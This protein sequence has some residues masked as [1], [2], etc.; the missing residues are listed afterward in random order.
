VTASNYK[1]H[2]FD[3]LPQLYHTYDEGYGSLGAFLH[4]LGATL[5]D[6]EKN[7][8]ELYGDSFI[9][10]C[11]AWVIPYI[12]QMIGARILESEG[13]RSRQEVM[14]TIDWR[15]RKGTLAAL[16]DLA[17]E[18]TG[19]G[20]E[21]AEFFEQM[22]W[23]QNLNHIKLDH[24]QSPDLAD[25]SALF[26][27]DG[28]ENKLLHTVDIRTP[29]NQ[30]GWFQIK[31]LGFFTAT[32][33]LNHYRQIPLQRVFGHPYQFRVEPMRYPINLFNGQSCFPLAQTLE[34]EE[35]IDGFGTGLAVDVH[36]QGILT[37]APA[38]PR[39]IGAPA[40][41]P[42]DPVILD[43]K[44]GDGLWP[45]D[46][47]VSG[48][49]PLK[50]TLT[51]MVL[52][53]K[54]GKAKLEALGHLDLNALPLE[55][56][57]TADGGSKPKPRLVMAVKPQSGYDRAFP[58]MVLRVTSTHALYE[59]FPGVEDRQS[60]I[61]KDR[62]Y[63][64]LPAV[65]NG[66]ESY[67]ALDRYGSAYSYQHDPGHA[68][69][70]DEELFDFT[71]LARVS[72]GVVCPSRELTAANTPNPPI[73]SLAKTRTLQVVDRGQFLSTLIPAQGFIIKAW[74]R[75]NQPGGGVLRLLAAVAITSPADKPVVTDLVNQ[76]C[77]GP[78]H[79]IISLHRGATDRIPE[80]E[81]IVM[82]ERG[83]ALLAYLPQVD[84]MEPEGAFFYVAEDGAT[85]RVNAGAI[86]GGLL[87]PR[88]PDA[89]LE[90]GFNPV[91]LARLSAGQCLPIQNKTPIQQRIA[92]RCDLSQNAIPCPGILAIDPVIG[93]IAFAKNERPSLPLAAGYHHGLQARV[94]AGA[95]F[96]AQTDADDETRILHVSKRSAPDDHWHLR[97]PADG[98]MS[99]V[100][101]HAC[102]QDA[103]QDIINQN[104]SSTGQAEPWIIQIEDSE[105]Y[106]ENLNI[107]A[108]IPCGLIMR[109]AQFQYPV[110]NGPIIWNGPADQ[111]TPLA[112][113]QGL[114]LGDTVR[115]RTG[116]FQ[117]IRFEDCTLLNRILILKAVR[118][119]EDR[120]PRV[121]VS[122]SIMRSRIS[123][124]GD[125][126]VRIEDSALDPEIGSA[127]VARHGEIEMECC[128]VLG[129][130]KA[131]E[132]SASESIFM[133]PVTVYDPQKGCMRYCR[134]TATG[135]TLPRTYRCTTAEV[136]FVHDQPWHSGYLKIRRSCN[137]A[138][139]RWAENG[140]EIGVYHQ[141]GYTLKEKNLN[142]KFEEYLPVGLTPVLIDKGDEVYG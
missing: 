110:I 125:C 18:I 98:I 10:S 68:Q 113:F 103:L 141:A 57:H 108:A 48:G 130:V 38:L 75:D 129:R 90:G 22:G 85:Y 11:H 126:L 61:Y 47:R 86:S 127:L 31:N 132:L 14:K 25:H 99:R 51:P 121:S 17:R 116:R 87:V 80:M 77:E 40:V 45:M 69:P 50:Y 128:T 27:Q 29:G 26:H 112:A 93:Q 102:I 33:A 138:V 37:A 16:E 24:L 134:I 58:A 135:N 84:D 111:I 63:V 83:K 7:I 97:P 41:A 115:F 114:V 62:L 136:T 21:A 104:A 19:W 2:L 66:A 79:L 9:E 15:K 96:H 117:K 71:R 5:D 100:K 12:G 34:P 94:G 137:A 73:Y 49:E 120:Y 72:E 4:A 101:I 59:V 140:G 67:F 13:S 123:L 60:G 106:T 70:P 20:V 81:L 52:Y 139:A 64:Y 74:N 1:E 46:W 56:H 8:A 91:L 42:V 3:L 119:D 54:N 53:E 6:M 142:L 78:G 88:Q 95:Y 76:S 124:H 55:F 23:S 32:A 65:P 43:I 28:A 35:R 44:D 92:V 133:K 118:A 131:K 105:I 39:W 109:A 36:S 107:N 82:N 89:G 30:K 122:N